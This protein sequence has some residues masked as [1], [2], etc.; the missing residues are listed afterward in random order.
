M[1]TKHL[2]SG[3]LLTLCSFSYA[4]NGINN[5]GNSKTETKKAEVI[6][7]TSETKP[8][9]NGVKQITI[10]NRKILVQEGIQLLVSPSEFETETKPKKQNDT[11]KQ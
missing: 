5:S 3:I 8:M 6:S 10:E 7:N 4:Q 11:P 9:E 2:L 1:K